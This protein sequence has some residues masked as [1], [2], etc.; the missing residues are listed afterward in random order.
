MANIDINGGSLL[1]NNN[2]INKN[3]LAFDNEGV[4]K[5]PLTETTIKLLNTTGLL[6]G[7]KGFGTS[8]EVFN[9]YANNQA[10]GSFAHAE[11]EGTQANSDH[12]HAQGRYNASTEGLLH[13]VGNGTSTEDLSDAHTLDEEGNAWFAGD[14]T[15]GEVEKRVSLQEIAN[16]LSA[17]GSGNRRPIVRFGDKKPDSSVSGVIGDIYCWIIPEDGE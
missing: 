13:V 9:D 8:A 1:T 17:T 2:I 14:V 15:I 4:Y 11:G 10:K 6:V 3:L 5:L 7:G 16:Q 12:M